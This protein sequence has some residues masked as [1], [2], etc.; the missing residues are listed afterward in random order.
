[1][2]LAKTVTKARAGDLDSRRIIYHRFKG[3][4][5]AVSLRYSSNQEQADDIFQ[6]TFLKVFEKLHTLKNPSAFPK[7]IKR[8]AI[9]SAID[10][11]R[12][13]RNLVV[14]ED[15]PERLDL[16]FEPEVVSQI[17]TN[18][19]L[20]AVSE[21]PSGYRLV[22]N[23]FVID[24]YSHKEIASKLG[25]SETTSRSQ[26]TYARKKLRLKFKSLEM[27]YNERVIR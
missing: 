24:G 7:W 15:F 8:M 2:D 26:L 3:M 12:D 10:E 22:F 11:V 13:A 18:T 21:L 1:M 20:R 16:Q 23:L 6:E 19:I 14:I 27:N 9:Y 25:I 5:M 4:V 17:D